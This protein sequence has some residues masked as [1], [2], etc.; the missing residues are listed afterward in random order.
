MQDNTI[1][2]GVNAPRE[3]QAI[4]TQLIFELTY[5]YKQNFTR[6]FPCRK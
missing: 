2:M 6:L 4:I 5:L 1:V 3:H